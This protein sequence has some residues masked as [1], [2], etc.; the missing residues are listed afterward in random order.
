MQLEQAFLLRPFSDT[1]MERV[2]QPFYTTKAPGRGTGM[3]LAIVATLMET[4]GGHLDIT[5]QLNVGTT[6][7]MYFPQAS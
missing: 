5:S 4:S 1:G 3:G 7:S 2:F 6:V